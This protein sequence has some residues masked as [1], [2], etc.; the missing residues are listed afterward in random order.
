[1]CWCC[2]GWR[3]QATLS[4]CL[5]R[6]VTWGRGTIDWGPPEAVASAPVTIARW[7][8]GAIVRALFSCW[9]LWGKSMQGL[10]TFSFCLCF[11]G[12]QTIGVGV[13]EEIVG[14][15][16]W[17]TEQEVW[18]PTSECSWQQKRGC[19]LLGSLEWHHAWAFIL[20]APLDVNAACWLCG[21][22]KQAKRIR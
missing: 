12:L 8:Y 17:R 14:W 7:G 20:G 22:G 18:Y 21:C 1:M 2:Y 3:A 10:Q 13:R 16:W 4:L 19:S 6:Q 11:F 5:F 15:L 9:Q